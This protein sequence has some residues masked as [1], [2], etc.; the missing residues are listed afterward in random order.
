ME[1]LEALKRLFPGKVDLS[2]SERLRHGK[3][4]GYPLARPVLAVVYPENVEDVQKALQWARE[5]GV[6]VIPYG[7][8]TSLEGH[9]Y[10]TQGGHQPGPEPHEPPP[11]GEGGGLPLR[12]GARPHPQG[13]ERG[14]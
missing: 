1:K 4:E 3:D 7:A 11:G 13:P 5:R 8:G 9:L 10:P 2:E 6:A 12:G 14:P